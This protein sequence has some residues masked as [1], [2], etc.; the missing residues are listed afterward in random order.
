MDEDEEVMNNHYTSQILT[1]NG[2]DAYFN[3][4]SMTYNEIAKMHENQP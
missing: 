3:D 4:D 1:I 2:N